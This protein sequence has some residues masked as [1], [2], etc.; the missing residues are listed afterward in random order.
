LHRQITRLLALEDAIDI[1]CSAAPLIELINPIGD[2]AATGQINR[3][4]RMRP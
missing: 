2:Q 3:G 1:S 4:S